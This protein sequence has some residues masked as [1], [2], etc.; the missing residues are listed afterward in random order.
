MPVSRLVTFEVPPQIPTR[1]TARVALM[2][3][4]T[5]ISDEDAMRVFQKFTGSIDRDFDCEKEKNEYLNEK[6]GYSG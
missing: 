4:D 5:K 1:A 2:W 3:H 6:Y